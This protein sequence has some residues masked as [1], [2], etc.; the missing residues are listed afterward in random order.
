MAIIN[1]T[2]GNDRADLGGRDLVGS[3]VADTISGL[4]GSD[5]LDGRGGNDFLDGGAGLD[6]ILGGAGD[7]HVRDVGPAGWYDGGSG[8]DIL[9]FAGMI[10][11]GAFDLLAGAGRFGATGISGAGA[12][13]M[14]NFESLWTGGGSDFLWGTDGTNELRSGA[15][16]DTVFGR[17]GADTLRGEAGS[18]YL[19]GGA[20]A[21]WL[22]GGDG[23]DFLYGGGGS[24]QLYGG[25]GDDELYGGA[26]NDFLAGGLGNDTIDGLDGYDTMSLTGLTAGATVTGNTVISTHQGQLQVDE[27]FRI[28][29]VVGTFFGDSL[30]ASGSMALDG[31]TGNDTLYS[32]SGANILA[33]GAG[34][35]TVSYLLSTAGV[36]VNL[37][38]GTVSGGYAAG[39]TLSGF[40]NVTGSNFGDVLRLGNAGGRLDGG[41]GNDTLVGGSGADVL[42]GGLG[43][44]T[45]TGGGGADRFVFAQAADSPWAGFGDVITDFQKGLDRI[46][47]SALDADLGRAG[48]Q[49]FDSLIV[50]GQP[51]SDGR[52]D[53]GTIA[54][55]AGGGTTSVFLN[56]D[57]TETGTGGNRYD[58]IEMAFRLDS[59]VSLS[60][61]DF[62]L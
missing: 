50:S 15:G 26:G 17:G 51:Y 38:N 16:D 53:A 13:T 43:Q 61:D 20:Q 52:F 36:R 19:D 1:G 11:G 31:S 40:E 25:A 60:L 45:L 6:T 24:D 2:S 21:D 10:Q 41:A 34:N 30:V 62:I 8:S 7:D 3:N 33:G 55:W 32:G 4:A 46:D 27:F 42:V 22:D 59:A 14:R 47:L 58:G 37:A 23:D 54:V 5:W 56:L 29:K 48:N 18:D 39:D 28:E 35:D 57:G 12:F 9:D 49:A 44:D